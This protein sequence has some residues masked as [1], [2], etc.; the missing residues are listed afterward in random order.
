MVAPPAGASI[1]PRG[2]PASNNVL[3]VV[4]VLV[5]VVNRV[6]VVLVVNRVVVVLVVASVVVVV[7]VTVDD[8]VE[9][10]TLV[11]EEVNCN[12]D[13]ILTGSVCPCTIGSIVP[14]KMRYKM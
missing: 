9:E 12:G 10:G 11:V 8:V 3:V 2:V 14:K 5:L 6:V 4:L 7:E 1:F 13:S